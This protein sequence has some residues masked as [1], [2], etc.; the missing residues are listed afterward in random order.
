MSKNKVYVNRVLVW[1]QLLFK[2]VVKTMRA[3]GTNDNPMQDQSKE[4]CVRPTNKKIKPTLA[5]VLNKEGGKNK[6]TRLRLNNIKQTTRS[7]SSKAS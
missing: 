5:R 4:S 1:N 3:R 7:G 6:Q 2:H